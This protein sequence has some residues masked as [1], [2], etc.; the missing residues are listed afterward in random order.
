MIILGLHFGHDASI[1]VIKDGEILICVERERFA[2]VKH[3]VGLRSDDI[4]DCLKDVNLST[5]DID[6]C[7]VTTTQLMEYIF[8]DSD[9]LSVNLDS[10][11]D[12]ILPCTMT[13][14]L[15][16]DSDM[17]SERASGWGEKVFLDK[18]NKFYPPLLPEAEEVFTS[19]KHYYGGFE[20]YIDNTLWQSVTSLDDMSHTDYQGV[21]SDDAV[22]QGFHYPG[23][24]TILG[25][26]VACYFFAHHFAHAAYSFYESP[27]ENAAI[28]THDGGGGGGHYG[29]GVFAYGEGNKLF[30]LTPHHLSVGE[31]YDYTGY[32]IGLG[33]IG[34]AGKLMGL[35]AYGKPKFFTTDFVGNWYDTGKVSAKEW[36]DH[37]VREAEERGY[38]MTPLGDPERI[39]APVNVD[40]AASTQRLAEEVLSRT[41]ET[42]YESMARSNI[43]SQ[44]LCFSGGFALNCP[45][46]SRILKT[47][48]FDNLFVPPA[49]HDGGL[50]A[51]AALALYF[52]MLEKDRTPRE[53]TSP[54]QAYLGLNSSSRR[55]VIEKAL[56]KYNTKI[57]VE[58]LENSAS[59]A[60]EMLSKNN[61]IAWFEGRSEI[62]PRA[63]GHRSIVSNPKHHENWE[64]VNIIKT[65]EL[66]RPLAPVI[67]EDD[68]EEHFENLGQASYFML[69]NFMT[70]TKDTPATTHVD[71]SA[72]V[73]M[74]NKD[75]GGFFELLTKFKEITG[76]SVLMNTSFNGPGEPVVELPGHAIE[77]LLSTDIDALF[78][79]GYKLT[80]K[81]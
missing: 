65:R 31:I 41:I 6:Y 21:L 68:I 38:D 66:W 57:N 18:E 35:S 17:M 77:F 19:K 56:E 3:V 7:A 73:Q 67:L 33:G 70:R 4:V 1:S 53:C 52:N 14:R 8:L 75:C 22:R 72:R 39:L 50:S 37:C 60:A 32:L 78:F 15:K 58:K 49:V 79:P 69:F 27:Y 9:N 45:A 30:T 80:R 2:R 25:K 44:N 28:F 71:G 36:F 51:G 61:I 24:L 10:H 76:T 5:D 40:I 55:D 81:L 64:R 63:L 47:G 13:D 59:E 23:T 74:V 54:A 34:G 16:V 46:N 12:H 29:C 48:P 42:L 62:G 43:R 11:P 26:K 20:H